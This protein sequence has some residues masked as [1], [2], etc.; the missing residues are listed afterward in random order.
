MQKENRKLYWNLIKELRDDNSTC[1]DTS[2]SPS[3]WFD[4]FKNL[5]QCSDSCSNRIHDFKEQLASM[6]RTLS[7]NELDNLITT[8]EISQAISGLKCCKAPSLDNIS[9]FMIKH[10]Q[11]VLILLFG[12]NSM[13]VCHTETI[14]NVMGTR[15]HYPVTY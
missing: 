2:I 8:K 15:I 4:H 3:K 6:E 14:T 9:Y 1:A 13:P 5:S 7:F 12:E 10:G 11:N